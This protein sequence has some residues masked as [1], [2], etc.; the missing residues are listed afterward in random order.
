MLQYTIKRLLTDAA[1]MFLSVV[2]LICIV[3][4]V[5]PPVDRG[6]Q[7]AAAAESGEA[8]R[9]RRISARVIRIFSRSSSTSTSRFSFNTRFN[10]HTRLK[11]DELLVERA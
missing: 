10:S 9:L 1:D 4:N 8:E 6:E 7:L 3:L 11:S 2:W 5:A